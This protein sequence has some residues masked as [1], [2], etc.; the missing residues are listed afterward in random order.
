MCVCERETVVHTLIVLVLGFNV[1]ADGA[2]DHELGR[3]GHRFGRG[4]DFVCGWWLA[5]LARLSV[6]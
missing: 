3:Q 2:L 6:C 4:A 5:Y 1:I